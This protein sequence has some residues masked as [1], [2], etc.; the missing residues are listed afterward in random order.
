LLLHSPA[1]PEKN[2]RQPYKR[3]GGQGLTEIQLF[4]IYSV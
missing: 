1:Q 3:V 4:L 2:D